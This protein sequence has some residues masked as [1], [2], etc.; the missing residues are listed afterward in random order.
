M[1]HKLNFRIPCK[2]SYP[3][4]QGVDKENRYLVREFSDETSADTHSLCESYEFV[5]DERMRPFTSIVI[6][7]DKSAVDHVREHYN[8]H[9]NL[10]S[11]AEALKAREEGEA[12]PLKKFHNSIKRALINR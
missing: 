5:L 3:Q 10:K 2:C 7:M 4:Q 9:S 1:I 8:K 12:F 6:A 11:Q